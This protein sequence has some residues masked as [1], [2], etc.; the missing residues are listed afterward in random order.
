MSD[1]RRPDSE[2]QF[3]VLA[4]HRRLMKGQAD[5]LRHFASR[6]LGSR[7]VKVG[8]CASLT[9][10]ALQERRQEGEESRVSETR[11]DVSFENVEQKIV[12]AGRRPNEY[13]QRE[14]RHECGL[15]YEND[16]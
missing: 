3:P 14:H 5:R 16:H 6:G 11:I 10:S 2:F 8:G 15:L 7:L 13:A 4:D 12:E 9:V 1:F